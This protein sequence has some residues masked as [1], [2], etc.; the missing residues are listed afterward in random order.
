MFLVSDAGVLTMTRITYGASTD[1]GNVRTQ[2]EDN[3][4]VDENLSLVADGMGGHACGEIASGIAVD[5]IRNSVAE[6]DELAD[7]IQKAHTAILDAAKHDAAKKGMGSTVVAA[8]MHGAE[9]KLAWVGDS[10]A[11][12]W[13]GELNQI[14]KDHSVVQLLVDR[15]DITEEEARY[16][17]R[18]SL[19]YESLGA[20]DITKV[21]VD[22]IEGELKPGQ[23]LLLCSDGL[24]DEVDNNAIAEIIASY[25]ADQEIA[26]NLISTV[27]S[28]SARDNITVVVMSAH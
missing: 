17:P 28:G 13:D 11:Y 14:S 22:L 24:S 25:D 2:N 6:G 27:L 5:T 1:V 21:G 20:S 26:D 8:H 15:G 7:A 23:K 9:Y 19:I 10:R 16:H 3:Y 4:Y 12:L 18:K